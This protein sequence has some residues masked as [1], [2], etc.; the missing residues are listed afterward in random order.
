MTERT[1]TFAERQAVQKTG[2]ANDA[3][4]L[5]HTETFYKVVDVSVNDT[6]VYSGPCMLF[7]VYVNTGLSA[8]VVPIKDGGTSGTTVVSIAASAAAGTSIQYH[9]IRFE[10]DMHVDPNDA[11]TGSI[12]IAYRPL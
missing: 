5:T 4:K 9:G 12:T 2:V 1:A 10:T 7:G 6:Q 11:A 3:S 8:H